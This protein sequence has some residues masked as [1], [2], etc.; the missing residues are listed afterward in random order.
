MPEGADAVVMVEET[1][2]AGEAEVRIFT[3]VYPRQHVGRRAADIAAGQS[4]LAEGDVLNPSRI[5]A[6]AAVGVFDVEVYAAS[7]RRDPL[8]RQRDRRARPP[9]R[10]R[11]DLRHQ[12]LHA[13]GD[14]RRARRRAVP[15]PPAPDNLADLV[16]RDPS[17]RRSG[18]RRVLRRQLGRRARP[19]PGRP[20]CRS[21]R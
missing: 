18:H 20:A 5:G 15:H 8:D 13:R 21:A 10:A 2:K 3:P 4:L 14:H 7:A 19:D 16:E 11:T 12:P 1:E 6:L 9:A 17:R